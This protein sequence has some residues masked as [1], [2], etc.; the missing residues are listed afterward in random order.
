MNVPILFLS[1][2][3][4]PKDKSIGLIAGGD[5]YISKPFE[6]IEL[7]A[8]IKAHL[9]RSRMLSSN[10]VTDNSKT[11]RICYPDLTIDI[12]CFTVEAYGQNVLLSPKEFQLLVLLAKNPEIVF[13][14]EKLFEAVWNTESSG[15]YRTLQVHI[16]NIRKKLNPDSKYSDFIHTVKGVG[17]KFSCK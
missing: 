17:Y 2:K 15:D 16:S 3:S 1:S 8:R 13:S 12:D 9:R 11:T 6:S 10:A 5:D 4:T 14:N 7:V